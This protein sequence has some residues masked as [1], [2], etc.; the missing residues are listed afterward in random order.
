MLIYTLHCGF[1]LINVLNV[2]S[3]G[4]F[5][6]LKCKISKQIAEV[7]GHGLKNGYRASS[8]FLLYTTRSNVQLVKQFL[9]SGNVSNNTWAFFQ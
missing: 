9:I 1:A 8:L 4:I 5:Q 3:C 7:G 2:F 6:L